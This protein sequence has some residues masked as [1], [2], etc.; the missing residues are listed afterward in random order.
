MPEYRRK[1][2]RTEAKVSNRRQAWRI[3]LRS[4]S[5]LALVLFLVA[6]FYAGLYGVR[7]AWGLTIQEEVPEYT[8]RLQL[9]NATA[10]DRFDPEMILRL[11]DNSAASLDITV[12]EETLFDLEKVQESYVL[13]RIPDLEAAR[14]LA[15]KLGLDPGRVLYRPLE[16]NRKLASA[17]LIVGCDYL[18]FEAVKKSG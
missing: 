6:G 16:D 2:R 15:R 11:T 17:S 13:S 18:R 10:Q 8:V 12:V 4:G 14:L 1:Q 7:L 5:A 9:I 3:F